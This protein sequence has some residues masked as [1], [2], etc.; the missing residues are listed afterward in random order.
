MM[1]HMDPNLPMPVWAGVRTMFRLPWT[2]ELA[3]AQIAFVGIPYDVA[4]TGRPGA[5]FGPTAIRSVSSMIAELAHYPTGFKIQSDVI[6]VDTGDLE[7]DIHNPLTV[8]GTITC[9][10]YTSDAADE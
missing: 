7:I 5:R 8:P 10:L 3:G 2:S 6:A 4:T 9:L 1:A